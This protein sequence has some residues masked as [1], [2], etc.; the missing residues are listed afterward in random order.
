ME[1]QTNAVCG[2]EALARLKTEKLG[3]VYP[4]EF[5][6]IAEKTKLIIPIGEKVIVNA[7]H[8]LNM[9]KVSWCLRQAIHI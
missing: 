6:P 2:F 9:L 5:I 4:V 7:F 3:L 8:F 1:L